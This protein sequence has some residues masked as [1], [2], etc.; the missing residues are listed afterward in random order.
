M[1]DGKLADF[2]RVPLG[3]TKLPVK[4]ENIDLA[5]NYVKVEYHQKLDE[6]LWKVYLK[7]LKYNNCIAKKWFFSRKNR[8]FIY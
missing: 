3:R 8:F 4:G 5:F 6:I 1:T 2:V 7:N